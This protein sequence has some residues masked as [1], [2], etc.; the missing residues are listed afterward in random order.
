MKRKYLPIDPET[1]DII[2]KQN[3]Q[4]YPISKDGCFNIPCH[5]FNLVLGYPTPEGNYRK[6]V[7]NTIE[8]LI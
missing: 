4:N 3:S 1:I 7:A 8:I 2:K 6:S 5:N